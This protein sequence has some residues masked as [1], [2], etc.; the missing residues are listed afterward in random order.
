[1]RI[2]GQSVE[3]R[4]RIEEIPA[5]SAHADQGELLEWFSK[6]PARPRRT[7]LVHGEEPARK[8]LADKIRSEL[9]LDV[10]LPL[11]NQSEELG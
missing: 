6:I 2:H 7:Y 10:R 1:M 11:R 5:L 9:S 8:A 4:A 3:V